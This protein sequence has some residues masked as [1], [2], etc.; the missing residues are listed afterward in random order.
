MTAYWGSGGID[1]LILDLGTKWRWVVSFT[2][3]PLY[4]QGKSP[5][6]PLYKR[7]VGP[8]SRSGRRGGDKNS[9]ALP[10]LKPPIIHPVE[11]SRL[12]LCSVSIFCCAALVSLPLPSEQDI[13]T[14]NAVFFVPGSL[15]LHGL[16][17]T[18]TTWLTLRSVTLLVLH[19]YLWM[20]YSTGC[21]CNLLFQLRIICLY[22][23]VLSRTNRNLFLTSK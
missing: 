15:L 6:Y 18:R 19:F 21:T 14:S 2:P 16:Q 11:L 17:A 9:Q 8:Q 5:W 3:R 12:H 1:H 13:S 22:E 20:N 23:L 10:R 4:P 7:L